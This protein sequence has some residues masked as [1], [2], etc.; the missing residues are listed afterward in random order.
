ESGASE[1][2][3][4]PGRDVVSEEQV[5]GD[6]SP[7]VEEV[8]QFDELGAAGMD[9]LGAL[10]EDKDRMRAAIENGAHDLDGSL[11]T[12]LDVGDEGGIASQSLVP[13]AERGRELGRHVNLID[14]RI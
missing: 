2:H 6:E 11:D 7:L 1:I 13:P 3:I 4:D 9:V 12:V 10:A 5:Q 14:R 8:R